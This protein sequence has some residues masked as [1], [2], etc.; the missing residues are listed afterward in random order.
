MNKPTIYLANP[1]G[2][3]PH[4]KE[5]LLPDIVKA[6]KSLGIEVWEPFERCKHADWGQLDTPWQVGLQDRRDVICSDGIFAICNGNPPD[7]GVMVELG[8]AIGLGHPTFLF[9]DD[10][11]HCTDT[12]MYPLNLMLFQGMPKFNWRDYY[13]TGVDQIVDPTKALAQ[14]SQAKLPGFIPPT[15]ES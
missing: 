15:R 14:W 4:Q 7:E 3:S 6:I 13:Y 1:Y 11:R 8:I 2:F 9:R 10:F 12:E 5:K